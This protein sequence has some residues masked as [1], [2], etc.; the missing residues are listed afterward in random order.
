MLIQCEVVDFAWS[1]LECEVVAV[2]DREN[3]S[4]M[5]LFHQDFASFNTGLVKTKAH[6]MNSPIVAL[7]AM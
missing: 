1:D 6:K 3:V 4:E 5:L 7:K 2:D